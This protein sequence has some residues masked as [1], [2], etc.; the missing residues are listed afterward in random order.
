MCAWPNF[1]GNNLTPADQLRIAD[2]LASPFD[3]ANAANGPQ[4][5]VFSRFCRPVDGDLQ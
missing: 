2:L 5:R 1:L 3:D 4:K